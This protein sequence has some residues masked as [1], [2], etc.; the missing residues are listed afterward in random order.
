[1][2]DY[3]GRNSLEAIVWEKEAEVDRYRD[4][5]PMSMLVS[6]VR[7][8]GLIE[9]NKPRDV[10]AAL[11]GGKRGGGVAMLAE[12]CMDVYSSRSYRG[13]LYSKSIDIF[14]R[15]V[16]GCGQRAVATESKVCKA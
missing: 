14:S 13:L 5:W 16:H 2:N 4:R 12:V 9:E 3:C 11:L 7:A 8:F 1:M 15:V 6:R 10:L